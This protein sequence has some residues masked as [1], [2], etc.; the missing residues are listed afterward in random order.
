M[1]LIV[2][3]ISDEDMLDRASASLKLKLSNALVNAVLRC[4]NRKEY[5]NQL[6]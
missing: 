3:A 4:L 1:A 5:Q 2:K 6:L